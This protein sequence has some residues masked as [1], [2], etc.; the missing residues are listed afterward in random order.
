MGRYNK[1]DLFNQTLQKIAN[2]TI[3]PLIRTNCPILT[4]TE[5]LLTCYPGLPATGSGRLEKV[6][7]EF[8]PIK[9]Y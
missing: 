3:D 1:Q 5:L 6:L 9:S 4:I 7:W 2:Q 8:L